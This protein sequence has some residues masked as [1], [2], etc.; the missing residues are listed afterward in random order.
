MEAGDDGANEHPN[1]KKAKLELQQE[2]ESYMEEEK[3]HDI[4]QEMMTACIKEMPKDPIQFL[5]EKMTKEESKLQDYYWHLSPL[6]KRIIV[7]TPPGMKGGEDTM[8]EEQ[9]NV[10]LMLE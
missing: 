1:I 3:L 8:N 5:I 10:A 4:F 2:L 6:E 9:Y 7:V